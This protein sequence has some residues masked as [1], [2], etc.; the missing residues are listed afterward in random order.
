MRK[1]EKIKEIYHRDCGLLEHVVEK[2]SPCRHSSKG[3]ALSVD[4]VPVKLTEAG[5]DINVLSS[6]ERLALPNP[7]DEPEEEDDGC[8]QILHEEVACGTHT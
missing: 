3:C 8:G 5:I 7:A 1:K 6:Q 4:L 2:S